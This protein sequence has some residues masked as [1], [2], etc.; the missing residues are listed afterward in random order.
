VAAVDADVDV[1]AVIA[2]ASS[3]LQIFGLSRIEA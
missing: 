2:L 1:I 3:D